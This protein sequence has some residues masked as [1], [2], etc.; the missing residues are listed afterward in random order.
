[1]KRLQ[2]KVVIV[3]GAGGG[4]GEGIARVVA[5]EGARTVIAEIRA[6]AGE[7][8]AAQIRKRGGKALALRCDVS[9]DADIQATVQ[10][11]VK[12]FGRVDGLVNNAGVNFVK[13][14]LQVTPED[15]QRVINIDLRGTF[16]FSQAAIRQMLRQKPRGGS[17]VNIASVHSHACYPGAAVYDA[18]KW[19]VVGVTKAVAIE[20]ATRGIRVNA[21]SPGLVNTLIWKEFLN[22]VDDQAACW[23]Y[24]KDNVPM[25]RVIEPEEIARLCVF[26]L[27][28]EASCMTGANIFADGGLTSQFASKPTF[29][30]KPVEGK[31]R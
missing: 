20:F 4:L 30:M 19:G 3:T 2:N 23:K 9:R 17:I 7:R 24:W 27:S 8:V 18:A 26:L 31:T 15:W 6:E 10:A 21:V 14:T 1:V 5:A 16:F 25:E 22:A 13:N 11:T 29:R 28:D 12:A